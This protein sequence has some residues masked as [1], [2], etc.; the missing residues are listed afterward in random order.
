MQLTEHWPYVRPGKSLEERPRHRLTGCV[1]VM[2]SLLLRTSN[3]SV[4]WDTRAPVRV[5]RRAIRRVWGKRRRYL[6]GKCGS[7]GGCE[8]QHASVIFSSSPRYRRL[9]TNHNYWSCNILKLVKV[10][11]SF[12]IMIKIDQWGLLCSPPSRNIC[13][14]YSRRNPDP[15][16]GDLQV[17]FQTSVIR[18]ESKC[19]WR[20]GTIA[21]SQITAYCYPP[22]HEFRP[23]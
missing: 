1:G 15:K 11:V 9:K 22:M 12:W 20:V 6:L 7:I 2:F 14:F 23:W 16:P 19:F 21:V 13:I 4:K 10:T 17:E 8:L 3:V 18:L 5:K